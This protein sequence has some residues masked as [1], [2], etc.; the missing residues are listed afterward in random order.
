MSL[1]V[2]FFF[3]KFKDW[4]NIL[5]SHKTQKVNQKRSKASHNEFNYPPFLLFSTHSKRRKATKL[6]FFVSR[7]GL[8]LSR[9]LT[10]PFWQSSRMHMSQQYH[11]ILPVTVIHHL[12]V[13]HLLLSSRWLNVTCQFINNSK[14]QGSTLRIFSAGPVGLVTFLLALTKC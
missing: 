7:K 9:S 3:S 2:G 1:T 4:C 8:R 10:M 12:C 11:L 14:R 6:S 5:P 13:L